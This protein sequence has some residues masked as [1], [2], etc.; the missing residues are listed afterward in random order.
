M[1]EH[2]ICTHLLRGKN[3]YDYDVRTSS[4]FEIFWHW[5]YRF[6]DDDYDVII[7]NI[8]HESHIISLCLS[9]TTSRQTLLVVKVHVHLETYVDLSVMCNKPYTEKTGYCID[10]VLT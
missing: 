4:S 3:N 6:L 9:F 8:K 7:I 2:D 10:M 5:L 1:L